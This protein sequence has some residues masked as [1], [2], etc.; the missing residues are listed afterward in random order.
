MI[1]FETFIWPFYWQSLIKTVRGPFLLV[2]ILGILMEMGH[3][4]K[5]IL[6]SKLNFKT[7]PLIEL[8]SVFHALL[9]LYRFSEKGRQFQENQLRQNLSHGTFCKAFLTGYFDFLTS[10]TKETVILPYCLMKCMVCLFTGVNMIV[11][12]Q[13]SGDPLNVLAVYY[14]IVLLRTKHINYMTRS[15]VFPTM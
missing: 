5:T 7:N 4:V 13:F 3:F 8:V 11:Y 9:R 10:I 14:I 1:F 15:M 2:N 12:E 6:F